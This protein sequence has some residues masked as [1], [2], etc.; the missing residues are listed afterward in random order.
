MR[1]IP[2]RNR[3]ESTTIGKDRLL[4][5]VERLGAER[6]ASSAKAAA[7]DSP[8]IVRRP[9]PIH[10]AGEK[11]CPLSAE[12]RQLIMLAVNGFT[13]QEMAGQLQLSKSTISRRLLRIYRKAGAGNR[14]DLV[15]AAVDGEFL[16]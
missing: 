15:L 6:H 3:P 14:F 11:N 16:N 4:R 2:I 9:K 5:S 1:I 7:G 13:N 12:E 8:R 10:Q